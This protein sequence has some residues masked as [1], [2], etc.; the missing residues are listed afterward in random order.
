[1]PAT[2]HATHDTYHKGCSACRWDRLDDEQKAAYR[3]LR[4]AQARATWRRRNPEKAA[5]RDAI[6]ADQ[7][8]QPCDRCGSATVVAFV[9][10]YATSTITWRCHSCG[11][12]ARVAFRRRREEEE[13]AQPLAA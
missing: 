9:T 7:T 11:D 12:A 6:V 1:M 5:L 3:F 4:S 13:A 2:P 10:D 8:P